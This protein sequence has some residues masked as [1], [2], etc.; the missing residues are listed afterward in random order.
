MFRAGSTRSI[1]P[2]RSRREDE[3]G[4][5]ALDDVIDS[6]QHQATRSNPPPSVVHC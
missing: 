2:Q 6:I 4:R 3:Q 1:S 5:Q